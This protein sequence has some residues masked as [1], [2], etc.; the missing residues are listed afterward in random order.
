ML[1]L[2]DFDEKFYK[3]IEGY[4]KTISPSRGVMYHTIV[5]DNE[6]VGVVGYFPVKKNKQ[7]G[8]VQIALLLKFR[9]KGFVKKAE[10]LLVKKYD[11]KLLWATVDKDNIASIKAHLKIGF[12]Q[13]SDKEIQR[14]IKDG[15]LKR[16]QIRLVKGF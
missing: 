10:E 12:R 5:V 1:I 8:F 4:R 7:A 15:F 6:K 16:D 9:G 14:L 2:N 3:S 11:I 13:L